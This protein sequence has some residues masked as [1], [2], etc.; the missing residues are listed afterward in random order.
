MY[1]HGC[2]NYW[3]HQDC[4]E[5]WYNKEGFECLVCREKIIDNDNYIEIKKKSHVMQNSINN[6]TNYIRLNDNNIRVQSR[7]GRLHNLNQS[8]INN[9]E[10]DSECCSHET[11]TSCAKI[12]CC[13]G[14][15]FGVFVFLS[16]N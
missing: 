14:M 16:P 7:S 6:G 12:T 1:Q 8:N 15:I 10:N 3:I 13:I 11:C 2:G 4:L 9:S 5:K